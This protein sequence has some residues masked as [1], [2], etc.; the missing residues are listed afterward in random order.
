MNKPIYFAPL[1][2]LA[3]LIA[4]CAPQVAQADTKAPADSKASLESLVSK[5]KVRIAQG[6]H[7]EAGLAG[8]LKEFDALLAAHQGEKTEEVAEIL[9]LKASLYIELFEDP[10]PGLVLLKRIQSDFPNTELSK[11]MAGMIPS[12]EKEVEAG[13]IARALAVGTT[14]PAFAVKDLKGQPLSVAGTKARVVLID[15]WATWC[16]P[17]MVELPNVIKAYDKYHARGFAIIGINLDDNPSLVTA[18]LKDHPLAWPQFSDGK[19][20]QNELAVKYGVHRIPSTYLLDA[21]GK[22]LG[23]DLFGDELEQALAKA[24]PGT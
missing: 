7:T 16:E 8:E 17:C 23:K 10:E 24:L 11:E 5:I 13:K 2:A 12:V 22:I 18:F 3:F 14:F 1:L 20:W 6:A 4:G 19:G 9:M 15:F 21:D